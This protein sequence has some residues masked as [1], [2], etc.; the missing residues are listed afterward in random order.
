MVNIALGS[1]TVDQCRAGDVDGNGEITIDEIIAAVNRA[2]A[3]C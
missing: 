2:L 1:A 3:G